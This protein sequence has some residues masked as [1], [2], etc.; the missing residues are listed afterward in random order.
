MESRPERIAA[1]SHSANR[2]LLESRGLTKSFPGVLALENVSF[3]LRAGE[4]HALVGENGAGK[5][6]LIKI[7]TG[8][9][10][11]DSGKVLIDGIT[12]ASSSPLDMRRRGV[13]AI[14]QELSL[15]PALPVHANL[16]LGQERGRRG[17]IDEKEEKRLTNDIMSRLGV[18][19]DP[20]VPVRSLTVAQQQMVEIGRAL[21]RDCRILILDE[22]SAALSPME[23]GRLLD[24]LRELADNRL[25]IVFISHRLEEVMQISDR[26]TVL[27]DGELVATRRTSDLSRQRLIEMMVGRTI[28]NEFPARERV[29]KYGGLEVQ[30]LS[31]ESVRDISFNARRGEVLGLAGLMGAGRTEIARIIFGADIASIGSVRI[32]GKELRIR[33]PRD[34]IRSGI[35]L[36]T[37]D[38]KYQ[39][40]VLKLSAQDNFA[41]GNLDRWSTGGWINKHLEHARF[42]RHVDA[43]RIRIASA[44]QRAETLSGGNQQKLLVAR[45]LEAE[46]QVVIFDEPTR[47][48]DVG[49]KYEMYNLINELTALGKVVIV[50]SS[51][52]QEL[53]GICDR[54]LV[55]RRGRIS[56]EIADARSA[57]QEEVM[58]LAV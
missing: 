34:A 18:R 36:L 39:G 1:E 44:D 26:I 57:S 24:I 10:K 27:R 48:I 3:D 43:L 50:I 42:M 51:E 2:P 38:R 53:L 9:H 37:E 32:D 16:F 5:S 17:L 52:L 54:L 4:I 19:I 11:P 25:G 41:L 20:D 12:V 23:V 45:W 30:H 55:I 31:G 56:G 14:Y 6:T 49:A 28:E 22:P 13:A 21:V 33:S 29:E 15:V 35:C 46:S 7:L 58:A 47:G 8:V 40:L